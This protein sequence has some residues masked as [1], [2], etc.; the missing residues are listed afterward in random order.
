MMGQDMT[1]GQA[2]IGC[3]LRRHFFGLR[4]AYSCGYTPSTTTFGGLG[5]VYYYKLCYNEM[6]SLEPGFALGRFGGTSGNDVFTSFGGPSLKLDMGY[7][8]FFLYLE[9]TY[10][11]L[12]GGLNAFTIGGEI[13][14]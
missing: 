2:D 13:V 5:G 7:K 8:H 11:C 12:G 3:S 10:Y 1:G 6:G 14:F 9:D 4:L